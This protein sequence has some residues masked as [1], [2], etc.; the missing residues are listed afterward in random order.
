MKIGYVA[1]V[2]IEPMNPVSRNGETI[3]LMCKVRG[4]IKNCLWQINDN[5]YTLQDGGKYQP[6][7]NLMDGECGITVIVTNFTSK[8]DRLLKVIVGCC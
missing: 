1:G 6:V 5:L 2:T 3:Q 4:V 7:G 8:R